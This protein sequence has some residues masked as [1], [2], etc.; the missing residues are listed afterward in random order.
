MCLAY[1][2]QWIHISHTD[3]GENRGDKELEPK[4]GA[5]GCPTRSAGRCTEHRNNCPTTDSEKR[6]AFVLMTLPE[7]SVD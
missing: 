6:E 7:W 1:S 3:I 5:V 2:K 4:A